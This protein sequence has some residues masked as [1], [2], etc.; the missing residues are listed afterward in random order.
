M[1]SPILKL[2]FSPLLCVAIAPVGNLVLGH[3]RRQVMNNA[4]YDNHLL[5]L[6]SLNIR[7]SDEGDAIP[8]YMKCIPEIVIEEG[9]EKNG[10]VCHDSPYRYDVIGN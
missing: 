9:K 2:P 7:L 6:V 1:N 5:L 4:Y 3:E 8:N 10:E